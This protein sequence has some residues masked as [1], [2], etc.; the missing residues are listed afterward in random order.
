MPWRRC[1]G[2]PSCSISPISRIR[3]ARNSRPRRF[4]E[5]ERQGCPAALVGALG[6]AVVEG[7]LR[8]K[9]LEQLLHGFLLLFVRLL[10]IARQGLELS[11]PSGTAIITPPNRRHRAGLR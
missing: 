5:K 1:S 6:V 7:L 3:R 4:F 11:V 2:S 9:L 10:G 8:R